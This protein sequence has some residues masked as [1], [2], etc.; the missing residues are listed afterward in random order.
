MMTEEN[1]KQWKIAQ[2]DFKNGVNIVS[3]E[4]IFK[5]YL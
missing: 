1:E 2:E 4:E 3:Q 5:K